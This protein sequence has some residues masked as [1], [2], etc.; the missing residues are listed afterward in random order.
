MGPTTYGYDEFDRL[1]SVNRYSGAQTF[2]NVYDRY[3]NRWQQ[4]AP[5]GGSS[6]SLIFNQA[7]NQT[8]T[9]GFTYNASGQLT[10]DS[11]HTYTYDA[12]GNPLTVD[13]G[14]TA[15]YVYDALNHRVRTQDANG[16]NEYLYDPAGK[17]ISTWVASSNYGSEGRIYWG[18]QQLAFRSTDG[19]TYFD[20]QDWTGTERVRTNYAGS[21]AALYASFAYGDDSYAFDILNASSGYN[22]DNAFYAGL[23]YDSGSETDHAM[24]RQYTPLQ[25]RWMGPDPYMGS[26]DQTNPQSFN[27]YGYAMNNPI[28]LTDPQGLDGG[29]QNSGGGGVGNACLGAAESLA[30]NFPADAGCAWGLF[31]DISG[32][33]GS[34]P[35]FHGTLS[36][37]PSTGSSGWDGNFG[38]S[39][40]IPTS[41]P[42]GSLSLGA[43]LGL[44]SQGCD[45][46][47]CGGGIDS[48][49]AGAAAPALAAPICA[50]AEPC[51]AIVL[52]AAIGLTVIEGG[53]LAHQVYQRGRTKCFRYR[54][55]L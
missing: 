42:Q 6:F 24:F 8:S 2:T 36:P 46:G 16:T 47:A 32:L 3:G 48:F 11:F 54:D 51:G 7:T 28:A 5:Q 1:T 22:Q 26:Y 40:G 55:S 4:N 43:A 18:N 30:W 19:T 49:Q 31:Q 35:S 20:H 10:D 50:I 34:G 37:R 23:D 27:R 25:G 39:L 15:Q 21:T 52:G 14:S 12:V 45:F 53:I 29:D 41:I 44:P 38:E 33:F 9:S 13:G 17:R